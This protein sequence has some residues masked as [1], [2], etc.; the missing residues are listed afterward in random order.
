MSTEKEEIQGNNEKIKEEDG[1][2]LYCKKC[3]KNITQQELNNFGGILC[4]K[5][6]MKGMGN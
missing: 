4:E 3:N 5:C 2:I 6:F 1:G